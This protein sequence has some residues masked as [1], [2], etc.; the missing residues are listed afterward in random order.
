MASGTLTVFC[1]PSAP[2]IIAHRAGERHP[3]AGIP[4]SG[5]GHLA[6]T[7][8]EPA[9]ASRPGPRRLVASDDP[10]HRVSMG[11]A[12]AK[13]IT[14]FAGEPE[15]QRTG[16]PPPSV[17]GCGQARRA[18]SVLQHEGAAWIRVESRPGW[19]TR[20]AVGGFRSE[21]V[22]SDPD[23]AN[24]SRQL[25]EGS[26]QQVGS[27]GWTR[28]CRQGGGY[29][30][31]A[32]TG[33][34]PQDIPATLSSSERLRCSVRVPWSRFPQGLGR[35]DKTKVSTASLTLERWFLRRNRIR[36]EE[37]PR[38]PIRGAPCPIR[39]SAPP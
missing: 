8:R 24:L 27:P 3:Q 34:R 1:L 29:A 25:G 38:R 30:T 36:L 7:A 23:L 11:Q 9:R 28:W 18:R 37:E 2:I 15:P 26:P 31:K 12:A 4:V 22:S 33:W 14:A 32:S 19:P 21:G 39:A 35:S 5:A 20:F 16:I 10:F 6:G 17:H 13:G